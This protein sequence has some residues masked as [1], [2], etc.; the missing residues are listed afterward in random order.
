MGWWLN[1][2][3][4]IYALIELVAFYSIARNPGKALL[5]LNLSFPHDAARKKYS[6]ATMVKHGN[7]K[8]ALHYRPGADI[9]TGY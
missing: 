4:Y 3:T 1:K 2:N 7:L 6:L 9:K 5:L 8:L